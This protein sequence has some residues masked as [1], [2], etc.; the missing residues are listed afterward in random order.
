MSGIKKSLILGLTY[1][2]IALMLFTHTA[3]VNAKPAHQLRP[4]IDYKIVSTTTNASNNEATVQLFLWYGCKTCLTLEQQLKN[5]PP[6]QNW[7]RHPAN[8]QA[9]WRMYSKTFL[10]LRQLNEPFNMDLQLMESIHQLG[11]T[12]K[13]VDTLASFLANLGLDQTTFINAYHSSEINAQME[14]EIAFETS[15]GL[16][17]IPAALINGRYLLDISMVN[18]F[19]EFLQRINELKQLPQPTMSSD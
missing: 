10:V 7:Q 5:D 17:K 8:L 19:D 18:S 11:S 13:D 12:F 15:L 3:S 9:N 1:F 16:T 14:Q 6:S 2:T 4:G